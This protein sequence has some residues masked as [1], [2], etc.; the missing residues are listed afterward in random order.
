ML[1]EQDVVAK[2]FSFCL[3]NS[4][5]REIATINIDKTTNTPKIRFVLNISDI[6]MK[7]FQNSGV[8]GRPIPANINIDIHKETLGI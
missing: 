1:K 2:D 7:L 8:I 3:Y 4:S 5:N 6:I